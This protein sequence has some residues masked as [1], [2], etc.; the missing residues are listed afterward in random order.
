[1]YTVDAMALSEDTLNQEV[2]A[3]R[4]LVEIL[5]EE[6]QKLKDKIVELRQSIYQNT[7][8]GTVKNGHT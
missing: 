3:L 1:M 7:K 5:Q 4:H 6:N 8:K 2:E